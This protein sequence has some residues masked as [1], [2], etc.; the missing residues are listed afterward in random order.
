MEMMV[1]A[2]GV[3]L[4]ALGVWLRLRAAKDRTRRVAW[5]ATSASIA[6]S[7]VTVEEVPGE[8][9]GS[10]D[11]FTAVYTYSIDGTPQRG[12]VYSDKTKHHRTLL[13]RYPAGAAVE[14]FYDPMKPARSEIRD[15]LMLAGGWA[16]GLN[17]MGYVLVP[18]GAIVAVIGVVLRLV[19]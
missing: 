12:Y 5:P 11:R 17:R 15:P 2:L 3:V 13:A 18:M 19:A 9:G 6:S 16:A 4:A 10:F 1:V 14:V 7:R 8:N